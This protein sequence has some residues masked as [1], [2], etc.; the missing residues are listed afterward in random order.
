MPDPPDGVR[1]FMK[2]GGQA[3]GGAEDMPMAALTA[4]LARDPGALMI[5]VTEKIETPLKLVFEGAGDAHFARVV[6]VIRPGASVTVLESH[7]GGAG[8]TAALIEFGVQ[9]GAEVERVLVQSGTGEDVQSINAVAHLDAGAV[10]RQTALA[11]GAKLARIETRLTH[12]GDTSEAHLNSAYMVASGRHAD[13]TSHVRHGAEDCITRQITKGAARKGGKGVFQGKFHV[14]RIAQRT[15][16]DMQ[17]NALLLDDGAEVNAKPE[18]EI[19]ADD[20]ACAHGNTCGA[21]DPLQLFYLRQRGIPKADAQALLTEAHI[22]GA[23][24]GVK[25][26]PA[27]DV[28]L[29]IAR[30]WLATDR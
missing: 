25:V 22:A 15:D 16:A 13:F 6:F 10:F 4:A 14:A 28:L 24:D 19:Y 26:E 18:L 21:L 11:T 2:T 9:E 30:D 29:Q 17:H 7:A 8:L 5:E 20:V 1:A 12:R 3:F 27:R 23:F